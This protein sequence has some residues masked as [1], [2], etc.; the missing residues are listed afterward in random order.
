MTVF[1]SHSFENKPEFDNI[2][3]ALDQRHIPYWDPTKVSAGSSLRD[4]LRDA[5]EQCGVCIF[6]ATRNA[7]DSSWC[8]AELGAFWGADKPIIVYLADPSLKDDELPPIVQG[9]VWERRIARIA[10]SARELLERVAGTS[11][12]NMPVQPSQVG[13]MTIEQLQ[14]LIVG[15]V[16]LAAA[17]EKR[18]GQ[19]LP[20]DEVRDA[21]RGAAGR[22]LEG[23][24][25]TENSARPSS[26]DW[27][28]HI[29][30]VDDHPDNNVYERQAFESMGL[31]FSL[32]L[33]TREALRCLQRASLQRSSRTWGARK[34]RERDMRFL[35]RF[36]RTTNERRFSSTL[37]PTLRSTSAR[38]PRKAP[39]G[40]LMWHKSLLIWSSK[41]FRVETRLK[42]HP[43]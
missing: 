24:R 33:S 8:G 5:V 26:P 28:R 12:D 15:A 23:I 9:D 6:I 39:K 27:H 31:R 2:V 40:Q 20:F 29:L 3:D 4:Q 43:D 11:T 34:G 1:I 25:A 18:E 30:W 7:I 35:S 37:A 10:E 21:A 14:K 42:P 32:A 13:N 17:A 36:G 22:M 41:R 16:A 19:S 38:R